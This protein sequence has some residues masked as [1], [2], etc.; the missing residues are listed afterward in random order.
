MDERELREIFLERLHV[1]L[2]LFRDSILRK[3]KADIYSKS[4]KIEVYRNL[5]EILADQAAQIKES[6][7][8]KLLYQKFGILNAFYE[9]WLTRD[10]SMHAELT[11]Y[12]KDELNVISASR[13]YRERVDE[14][15]EKYYEAA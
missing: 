7:L 13:I 14:Y 12:V 1:E 3:G 9:E 15:G 6:L 5:Y 10:D 4:Y 2:H 11:D 8:R